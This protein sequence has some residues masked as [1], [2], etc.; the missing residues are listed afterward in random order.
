MSIRKIIGSVL[1]GTL[2]AVSPIEAQQINARERAR[3]P[4][5]EGLHHMR[6]EAFEK[7]AQAF[8]EATR[9]DPTFEMAY[10]QLG[11]A[12]LTLKNFTSAVYALVKSRDLFIEEAGNQ[13]IDRQEGRRLRRERLAE[14]DQLI[15]DTQAAASLPQNANRRFKLLEQVRQYQERKRQIQ[16]LDRAYDLSPARRVPA[17]VSLS[18]GS[19]YFRAGNLAEAERAYEAA[20]DADPKIGEA[21]NNLAVV[22][23]ETGRYEQ[24]ERAVKEAEK[25]GLTVPAALKSEIARRKSGT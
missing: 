3:E 25:T 12:H 20:I 11:R 8:Q 1:A 9:I 6:V 21:H 7:A 19:A 14:L 16:D 13:F 2:F 15:I 22:Y 23:M 17:Y 5:T 24:A 10:Y 4:Y 18:L